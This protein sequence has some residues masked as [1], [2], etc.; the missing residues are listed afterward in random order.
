MFDLVSVIIPSYNKE[1]FISH[2]IESVI[3]QT[4]KNIEIIV[5]DDC[6]TDNSIFIINK[7][8]DNIILYKNNTNKGASYCRN[9]GVKKAKGKFIAHL[10]CDDTYEKT[11]IEESINFFNRNPRYSFIYTNVNLIDKKNNILINKNEDKI[12]IIG[13]G[14]ITEELLKN[15]VSVTNSTLIA[16]KE[17]F[18]NNIFF[19][20]NI[21]IASDRDILINLSLKYNAG[22]MNIK[23][24]NYRVYSDN[25]IS[26]ID[27]ALNEFLY[28]LDKYKH[29]PKLRNKSFY[30]LCKCNIY[31]NY[32]KYYLIKGNT[33]KAR[34]L[35]IK[36]ITTNLFYKKIIKVTI[37]ITISFLF[38]KIVK[39]YFSLKY[40]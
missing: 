26:N 11:K 21:F 1:E 15:E 7:Y 6:S 10:D 3:N 38:P 40:D 8:I 33:A 14:D 17:C 36:I 13:E 32:S 34:K 16:K 24:T 27:R 39:K 2:T 4:Y 22:F 19:D 20:E 28:V 35:L 12:K 25:I 18:A 30:K 31:Y 23:L 9:L 37:L 5:I 29:I